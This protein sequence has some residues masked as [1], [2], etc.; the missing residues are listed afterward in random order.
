MV[1]CVFNPSSRT[2]ADVS[3][4]MVTRFFNPSSR[5]EADVSLGLKAAWSI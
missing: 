5:T 3:L 4:G 2:E 1:T